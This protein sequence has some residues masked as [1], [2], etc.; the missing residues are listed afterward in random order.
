MEQN[1][2]EGATEALANYL[3]T[4]L[5]A[6]HNYGGQNKSERQAPSPHVTIKSN[7]SKALPPMVPGRPGLSIAFAVSILSFDTDLLL[8]C[9]AIIF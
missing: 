2:L 4:Y 7:D 3:E 9:L 5:A 6:V 1:N 8:Y